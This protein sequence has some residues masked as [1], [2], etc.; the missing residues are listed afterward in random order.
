[1]TPSLHQSTDDTPQTIAA[2]AV[3]PAV[4]TWARYGLVFGGIGLVATLVI[5]LGAA[6]GPTCSVGL[7]TLGQ[8]FAVQIGLA[9]AAGWATSRQGLGRGHS[10]F[11]GFAAASVA[12]LASVILLG[13]ANT[14]GGPQACAEGTRG[15][16]VVFVVVAALFA[17]PL[18]AVAGAGAGWLGSLLTTR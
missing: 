17:A 18:I 4:A 1:M 7:D 11:A 15:F 16:G 6:L 5:V 14:Q 3:A 2:N 9:A 10:A 8:A 13:L 12:G